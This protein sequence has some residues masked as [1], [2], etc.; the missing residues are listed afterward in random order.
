MQSCNPEQYARNAAAVQF[1]PKPRAN[2]HW[3]RRP[4][5]LKRSFHRSSP[6]SSFIT[7]KSA[8]A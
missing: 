2:V 3:L 7:I 1:E 6:S 5:P 8:A 4:K